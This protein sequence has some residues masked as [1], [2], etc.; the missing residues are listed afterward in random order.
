[1]WSKFLLSFVGNSV[2]TV[3]IEELVCMG[4]FCYRVYL[5]RSCKIRYFTLCVCSCLSLRDLPFFRISRRTM[6]NCERGIVLTDGIAI[7]SMQVIVLGDREFIT[8]CIDQILIR[9]CRTG[10]VNNINQI[11]FTIS[12]RYLDLNKCIRF[13][14]MP[15]RSFCFNNMILCRCFTQQRNVSNVVNLVV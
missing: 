8:F 2:Y 15:W 4:S 5:T 9:I 12:L 7:C 11:T 3:Q 14:Q 13:Q 1:M 10:I 6:I